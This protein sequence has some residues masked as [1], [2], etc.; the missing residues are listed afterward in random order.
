MQV[1]LDTNIFLYAAGASHPLLLGRC[2]TPAG[3]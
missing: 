3:A 2:T 1:F